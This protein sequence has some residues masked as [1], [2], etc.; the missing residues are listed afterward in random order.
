MF[1]QLGLVMALSLTLIAFEWTSP[2]DDN[3]DYGY[4]GEISAEEE[5]ILVKPPE[6]P[7]EEAK[8]EPPKVADVIEFFDDDV[9]LPTV[10]IGSE[11]TEETKIDIT[12]PNDFTG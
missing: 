7:E 9:K 8:P 2:L 3:T 10:T 11:V 6:P 12:L 5:M 1:L 4:A